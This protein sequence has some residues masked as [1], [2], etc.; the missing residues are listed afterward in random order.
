[1]IRTSFCAQ[2]THSKF[3]DFIHPLPP[4]F[5]AFTTINDSPNSLNSSFHNLDDSPFQFSSANQYKSPESHHDV[6]VIEHYQIP[7]DF[8]F[9]HYLQLDE[10][11]DPTLTPSVVIIERTS[12]HLSQYTNSDPKSMQMHISNIYDFFRIDEEIFLTAVIV[13][14]RYLCVAG[15]ILNLQK[16][17]ELFYLLILCIFIALKG[18]LDAPID[19][20][21]IARSLNLEPS[22]IFHN[23]VQIITALE[24]S[25]F[26][27]VD[28]LFPLSAIFPIEG[29]RC[30]TYSVQQPLVGLGE[31]LSRL[32]S[33]FQQRFNQKQAKPESPFIPTAVSA[34]IHRFETRVDVINVVEAAE[35]PFLPCTTSEMV[36]DS[37]S[38]DEAGTNASP[39]W[40]HFSRAQLASVPVFVP[41]H[42]LN[43]YNMSPFPHTPI[44]TNT[45][46]FY[47]PMFAPNAPTPLVGTPQFGCAQSAAH[48]SLASACPASCQPVSR[49]GWACPSS[50]PTWQ[51]G[52]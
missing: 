21:G 8:F 11:S 5:N 14:Y 51:M 40:P 10:T 25:L 9:R 26:F 16:D 22:R 2:G 23:E 12:E 45:S 46:P 47:P 52:W 15:S 18:L 50:Q 42:T 19:S 48:D 33:P 1:M 27:D 6:M 36:F 35:S 38:S 20:A 17:S 30:L 7:S 3:C 32:S 28:T 34:Y 41:S 49:P 44:V 39:T 43:A 29:L 24:F 37:D 13:L 31:H 4:S